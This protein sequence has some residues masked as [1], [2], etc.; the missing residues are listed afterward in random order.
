MKVESENEHL[1]AE[2]EQIHTGESDDLNR[3]FAHDFTAHFD[4]LCR[5][6]PIYAELRNLFDLALVG[7]GP[8]KRAWPT[9]SAG[10]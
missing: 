5:K 6:Y 9:R 3:K 1:T 7:A 8:P 2:G 4:A 10:T